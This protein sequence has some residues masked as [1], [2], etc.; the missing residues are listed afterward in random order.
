[1]GSKR[2]VEQTHMSYYL[3]PGYQ[4][5][6]TSGMLVL[7][8][9][10]DSVA[11]ILE[12]QRAIGEIVERYA[13]EDSLQQKVGRVASAY[14]RLLQLSVPIVLGLLYLAGAVLMGL[15]VASLYCLW[16]L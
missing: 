11:V 15:C 9:P 8:R 1:M 2:R 5:E 4:A 3:P 13:W 10:D 7:R 14:R 6:W 12:G 16:L